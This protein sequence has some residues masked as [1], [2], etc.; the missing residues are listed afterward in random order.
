MTIRNINPG[1]FSTSMK[2]NGEAKEENKSFTTSI[3]DEHKPLVPEPE[4]HGIK[5]Y[6]KNMRSSVKLGAI[7]G[8]IKT[9][10]FVNGFMPSYDGLDNFG[11]HLLCAVP[12]II[13]GVAGGIVGGG[14]GLV[15]GIVGKN[16]GAQMSEQ[17]LR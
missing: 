13:A 12:P 9:G 1:N 10:E 5:D 2:I 8:A 6:L 11:M 15:L 14:V 4:I 7:G 16:I 3:K 17:T